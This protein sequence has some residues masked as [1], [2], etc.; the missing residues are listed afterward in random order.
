VIPDIMA[1]AG[2]VVVSYFE[3]IQNKR[4]EAWQ[5]AEVDERL[6]FMMKRAFHEMR[7]FA[8]EH[9]VDNRTAAYAVAVNRINKV[10]VERGVFP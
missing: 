6:H 8:R 1:N 9:D 4:A 5:L 2:G 10:Y 7:A 3:W